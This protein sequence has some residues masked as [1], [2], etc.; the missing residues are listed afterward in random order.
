MLGVS[1]YR[2]ITLWVL[3]MANNPVTSPYSKYIIDVGHHSQ[4]RVASGECKVVHVPSAE[5]RVDLLAKPLHT[6]AFRIH[7]V[8]VTNLW[9]FR[10][11]VHC[12]RVFWGSVWLI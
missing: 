10:S 4:E 9:W 2:R 7:R 12:F 3:H 5:E 11:F 1:R 8:F 6:E